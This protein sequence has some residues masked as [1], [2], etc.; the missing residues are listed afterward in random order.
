MF[1]IDLVVSVDDVVELGHRTY[2]ITE[3]NEIDRTITLVSVEK[4]R[5][6]MWSDFE[7]IMNNTGKVRI[8]RDLINGT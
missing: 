4:E 8:H 6:M 3:I 2:R 7:S 1:E 5:E